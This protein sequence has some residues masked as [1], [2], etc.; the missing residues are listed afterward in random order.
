MNCPLSTLQELHLFRWEAI[1]EQSLMHSYERPWKFLSS[2]KTIW[3]ERQIVFGS[4]IRKQPMLHIQVTSVIIIP[5]CINKSHACMASGTDVTKTNLLNLSSE[6]CDYPSN[7]LLHDRRYVLQNYNKA[8]GGI[9]IGFSLL[10][11]L[12]QWSVPFITFPLMVTLFD[13][14]CSSHWRAAFYA[15]C[16]IKRICPSIVQN[17]WVSSSV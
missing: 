8:W 3:R 14:C 11:R 1:S 4:N 5:H 6:F 12:V 9:C 15:S 10:Q 2:K 16:D 7:I 17:N 13:F